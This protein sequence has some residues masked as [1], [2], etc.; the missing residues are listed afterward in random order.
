L[1]DLT[2]TGPVKEKTLAEVVSEGGRVE[3]LDT[4]RYE[5]AGNSSPTRIIQEADDISLFTRIIQ[6]IHEFVRRAQDLHDDVLLEA[7]RN[8]DIDDLS[9]PMLKMFLKGTQVDI[10]T[11]TPQQWMTSLFKARSH[12]RKEINEGRHY[13]YEEDEDVELASNL[14]SEE[15]VRAYRT[16]LYAASGRNGQPVQEHPSREVNNTTQ[17]GSSG[18]QTADDGKPKVLVGAADGLGPFN[19]FYRPTPDEKLLEALEYPRDR[20]FLLRLEADVISF[21]KDS[22]EPFIDLPPCN[23]FH[24]ML[25]H[26]LADYFHMTHQVDSVA[27]TVRIFRTPFFRLPPTLMTISNPPTTGNT[28]PPSL[29]AMKIMRRGGD[30]DELA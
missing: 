14:G 6:E 5:R 20:I 18:Q 23:S 22:E 9:W 30:R 24:R 19:L 25:T 21:V 4:E 17:S 28:P 26:K 8:I 13:G 7:A 10:T 2:I 27:G 3:L 16:Q 29:P 1:H 15:T 11:R 12:L